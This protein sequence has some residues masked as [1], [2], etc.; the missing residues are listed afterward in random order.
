[1]AARRNQATI[2]LLTGMLAEAKAGNL[3]RLFVVFRDGDGDYTHDYS[4]DDLDDLILQV[5]TE[6]IVAQ[7]E[8]ST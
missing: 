3:D 6:V 2:D 7:I 4:T 1:M 8:R 5:R